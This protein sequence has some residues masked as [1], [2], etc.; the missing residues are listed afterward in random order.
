MALEAWRRSTAHKEGSFRVYGRVIDGFGPLLAPYRN[1]PGVAIHS[2]TNDVRSVLQDS[3][4]LILPSFEEGSAL[5]TYEAQGCGVA[6][7]VSDAAGAVCADHVTGLVHRAGDV[8]ALAGHL[9]YLSDNPDAMSR[10]RGEILARRDHDPAAAAARLEARYDHARGLRRRGMTST[11]R[12]AREGQWTGQRIQRCWSRA[13]RAI[14]APTP[15]RRCEQGYSPVVYDD[16]SSGFRE[17]V[18]WGPFVKGDVRDRNALGEAIDAFDIKAVIHCAG[19]IEVGRSTAR[20]D[21]FWAVNVVGTL[22]LLSVMHERGVGRLVFSSSAA[23][24]GQGSRRAQ[25]LIV[26]SS[27]TEPNS[28][29]G[30]TKL[31]AEHMI[32]AHCRAF[33]LTAVA[34]R[35]FNAAGADSS[36]LIGEAHDPETHL[37]PLAIS[38]ALGVGGPLTIFGR[39]FNT[40]DGTCLSGL[41]ARE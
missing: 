39:D 13:A 26:E 5:V 22:N 31:A 21:L 11:A 27:D 1:D 15:Q 29:Y 30:D 28:P 2:F 6:P 12:A 35:Y 10:M 3:D 32:A 33:G 40:P 19:L 8:D 34:L 4:V 14:S 20:P 17:A 9:T 18:C 38:A 36:G 37:L 41:R 25:D 7:L 24:Y 16:L 23:V